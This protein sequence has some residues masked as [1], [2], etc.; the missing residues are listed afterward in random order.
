MF[1]LPAVW[2]TEAPSVDW[3]GWWTA[4]L[5]RGLPVP[6]TRGLDPGVHARPLRG[7]QALSAMN[8]AKGASGV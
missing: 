4:R 7:L 2:V 3:R 8:T 1:R 5:S 6:A